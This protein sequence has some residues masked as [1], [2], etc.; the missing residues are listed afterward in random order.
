[1][2]IAEPLP[3]RLVSTLVEAPA[4]LHLG[5]LDPNG[6]L[7][8]RFASLGLVIDG[9]S[10]E[11]SLDESDRDEVVLPDGCGSDVGERL[12]RYLAVLRRETGRTQSL[13]ASL[14]RT[15]P[16]HAGFGSGTQ[17]A[18]AFG[19]AFA[20][21]YGLALTTRE[22]AGLLGR[23]E[24]SGIGIAGFD[25]GG[26]LLDGG[27]GVGGSIAPLLAQA[28]FPSAWRVLLV[29]DDSLDGLHGSAER[30]ALGRL[31]PFS[32]ELAAELCHRVLMQ[33]LPAVLEADFGPFAEALSIVQKRIGDYFAPAQGGSM[34]TSPAVERVLEW[35]R[36]RYGA[37]IGQSSWGPTG[38][39]VLPSAATA[40]EVM[41]AAGAAGVVAPA[42]RLLVVS[43]RN[44]GALVTT[45]SFP[46]LGGR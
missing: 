12:A 9:M 23:G 16:A 14:Y 34:Y 25:R 37:G 8:R 30:L 31:P 44:R 22:I 2:M 6:S 39:A 5:F 17:L 46:R 43:G 42:L 41:A 45:E 21:H 11:L 35:I 27:P 38:F 10:A 3:S 15:P 28:S 36:P 24:R 32:R 13:R 7:G 1:M 33:L 18:L 29:L 20:N 4:R 26:L 19:R 40:V